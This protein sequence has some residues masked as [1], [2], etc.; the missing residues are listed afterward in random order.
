MRCDDEDHYSYLQQIHD[1]V[2]ARARAANLKKP[3]RSNRSF[4]LI[5]CH[6]AGFTPR[7]CFGFHYIQVPSRL[8]CLYPALRA[9]HTARAAGNWQTR[10]DA[11]GALM[12][13]AMTRNP[14]L[15]RL[16]SAIAARPQG[17]L[18]VDH[19]VHAGVE[20]PLA[21][22]LAGVLVEVGGLRHG[23]DGGGDVSLQELRLVDVLLLV[24]YHVRDVHETVE[25]HKR[26]LHPLLLLALLPRVVEG[27]VNRQQFRV[28]QQ[29]D[30]LVRNE[31]LQLQLLALAAQCGQVDDAKI[32]AQ[33]LQLS[34][35][36]VLPL[37]QAIEHFPEPHVR[38]RHDA[39]GMG[40]TLDGGVLQHRPAHGSVEANVGLV[41]AA[42]VLSKDVDSL[43][44]LLLLHQRVRV[45]RGA[46]HD[47]ALALPVGELVD[48]RPVALFDEHLHGRC[49][50]DL[51]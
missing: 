4:E 50:V 46:V 31:V 2:E 17:Q 23:L 47:D 45:H 49:R 51:R 28:S 11:L 10:D 6:C 44:E 30:A 35:G 32:L 43:H 9:A 26:H 20:G 37:Q 22:L 33:R 18:V 29:R 40:L 8:R 39:R 25:E 13:A 48:L 27:D 12:L 38:V 1:P 34:L 14:R 24:L 42:S 15:V 36:L 21:D 3:H 16:R 41:Q 7:A 19:L 5:H